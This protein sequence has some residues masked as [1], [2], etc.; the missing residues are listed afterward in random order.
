MSRHVQRVWT[1]DEVRALGVRTDL[2]TAYAIVVGGGRS[3]A[4]DAYHANRLPFPT[5]RS[6]RRVIVPVAALLALLR[7]P[8]DEGAA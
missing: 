5:L 3:A 6:G 2:V 4:W 7:I 1:P 8:A